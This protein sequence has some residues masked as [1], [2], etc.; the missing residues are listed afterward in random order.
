MLAFVLAILLM[1]YGTRVTQPESFLSHYSFLVALS[2]FELFLAT[3]ALPYNSHATAP[4]ALTDL[5]S[6]TA[7]LLIGAQ[8][9]TP[10]DR[11]LSISNTFFDPGDTAELKS[12][13]GDQLPK[14]AFNDLIV[15]TKF[16]EIIAPNLPLYYRLPAADGYDGGLLPL[17]NYM[18]FQQLFVDPSL[19]QSDGRLREQLKSIPDVSW[20]D[21]MNIRYIIT[22]KT[23]DQ[24]YD[25]VM[26]D[27]QFSTPLQAG[28]SAATSQLPALP[29]DAL[30]LVYSTP[31][32]NTALAA[33]DLMLT[34]GTTQTLKLSDPCIGAKAA[35]GLTT[36]RLSWAGLRQVKSI[37][38]TGLSGFTLEG[39]ALIDQASG[40]FQSFVIAPR[41]EFRLVHSG[42]VKVYENV[43][44]LPRTFIVNSAVTVSDDEVAIEL[45]KHNQVDPLHAVVLQALDSPMQAADFPPVALSPSQPVTK[46]S[47]RLVS[48]DPEHIVVD[49]DT[50][51]DGYLVITDAYYPGW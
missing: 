18:T 2:C 47:S 51:Q 19:I 33:I 44:V 6:A 1:K 16:K 22:D 5:R 24:W 46:S 31:F 25:G 38:V 20:L 45:M 41:G 3:R 23:G 39:A 28:E 32:S 48:Y 34:D 8:D 37:R 12:I 43:D 13:F 30:G 15:A 11:F 10:P 7:Q 50:S 29:A 42:D 26:Y 35:D 21:L 40:A 14:D 36:C 27:L 17:R 49:V 9:R 4:D